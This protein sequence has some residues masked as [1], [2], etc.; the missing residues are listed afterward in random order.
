[1]WKPAMHFIFILIA[2]GVAAADQPADD[3]VADEKLIQGRW[4][5]VSVQFDGKPFP[6]EKGD[7]IV[8]SGRNWSI[9]RNKMVIKS[10]HALDP[11]K[12]P[13]RLDFVVDRDGTRFLLHEIYKVEGNRLTLCE[14]PHADAPR[15]TTFS[16]KKG[17]K[18]F[19]IVLKRS[20]ANE[21]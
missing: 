5:Y 1:M 18:Q 12:T 7:H 9:H 17:E 14:P 20:V 16:A 2:A 13:K 15:P 6:L 8:I 11:S 4:E 21:K 10:K 19:L 3:T